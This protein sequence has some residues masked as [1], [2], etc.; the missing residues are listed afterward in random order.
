MHNELVDILDAIGPRLRTLRKMR[1]LT[2]EEV[3]EQS[4]ISISALSR[5]ETGKRKPTLDVLIPLAR[6]YRV[7]LDSIVAAPPTGDPR[8]HLEPRAMHNGGVI[9]PLTQYPGRVQVFKHVLGPRPVR[10]TTH[11]GH[12]WLYVLSGTLK[13]L[14]Q[15]NEHL[16]MPGETAQFDSSTPHWFGPADD[17]AVEILHLFG[18][19]GDKPLSRVASES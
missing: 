10:L 6:S 17:V 7:S 3:A 11:K 5:T 1:R 18:P 9:V 15:D 2:L 16:L 4:G 14:L 19:H 12:A 13:L 8:V